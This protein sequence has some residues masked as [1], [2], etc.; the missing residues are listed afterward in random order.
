MLPMIILCSSKR[1]VTTARMLARCWSH[2]CTANEALV[3]VDA[4]ATGGLV[5]VEGGGA[6]PC[7]RGTAETGEGIVQQ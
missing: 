2:G 1:R 3:D 6:A 7:A 5:L 4:G